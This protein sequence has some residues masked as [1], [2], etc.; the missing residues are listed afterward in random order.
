MPSPFDQSRYQ[1]RFD[2]G[3]DGLR[4]LG[5]SDVTVVVDVLLLSTTLTD[6]GAG[7]AVP[8]GA[9]E[10]SGRAS[11][12]LGESGSVRSGEAEAARSAEAGAGWSAEAVRSANAAR[13]TEAEAVAAA[14]SDSVVLLGCL[15]NARAVADAVRAEQLRRGAR[16]SVAVIAVGDGGRGAPTR[17]AVEDLLGAGAVIDALANVGI[18]H[19][20]PEA[21]AA[22]E[23]FRGLR[24]ALR[25]MLTASGSGQEMLAR[26]LVDAVRDAA[27]LDTTGAVPRLRNGAFVAS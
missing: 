17:F 3:V 21:A 24:G 25:H 6:Q 10:L 12:M 27:A 5:P 26:G 4:R 20:S 14:A 2:W 19:S 22:C 23:A 9:P 1:V 15:R 8:L 16:A 13:S 18:D 11:G 7:D